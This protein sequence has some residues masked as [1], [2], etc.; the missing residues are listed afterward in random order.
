[1]LIKIDDYVLNTDKITKIYVDKDG[2]YVSVYFSKD[3]YLNFQFPNHSSQESF[4]K[5]IGLENYF[6]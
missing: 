2:K 6:A 5:R 1:M 3:D 4:L